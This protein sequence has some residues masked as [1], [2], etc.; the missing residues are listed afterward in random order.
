MK[1]YGVAADYLEER[2]ICPEAVELLRKVAATNLPRQEVIVPPGG[3]W[4]CVIDG[5]WLHVHNAQCNDGAIISVL[6]GRIA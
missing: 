5:I 4:Q 2:G 3:R 6:G 1:D